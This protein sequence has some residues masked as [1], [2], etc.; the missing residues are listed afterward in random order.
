MTL[1]TLLGLSVGDLK[2][3]LLS[4]W[5]TLSRGHRPIEMLLVLSLHRRILG[6]LLS[7]VLLLLLL[8]LHR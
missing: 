1:L 8:P 4:L 2:R 7:E 3:L 5:L 6:L